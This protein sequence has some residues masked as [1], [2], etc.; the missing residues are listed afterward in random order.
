[1]LRILPFFWR[2]LVVASRSLSRSPA[3]A[4]AAVLSLA[5]GIGFSTAVLS[6]FGTLYFKP[7]PVRDPQKLVLL[8]T[9]DF[10]GKP[11]RWFSYPDYLELKRQGLFSGL[12]AYSTQNL[13]WGDET[14]GHKVTAALS[15]PNY[16]RMLGVTPSFGRFLME[17]PDDENAVVISDTFRKKHFDGRP[18]VGEPLLLNGVPFTIIGV[19]RAG[20]LGVDT[21]VAVDVWI[22][23]QAD[24]RVSPSGEDSMSQRSLQWLTLIGRL[25]D[26]LGL[27]GAEMALNAADRRLAES[28]PPSI[29]KSYR[30]IP[31]ATGDTRHLAGFERF[32]G[33]LTWAVGIAVAI[34]CVN[35][36]SLAMARSLSRRREFALRI[37]LGG[38]RARLLREML[39]ESFTIC[40]AGVV[41]ALA[42]ASALLNILAA[43]GGSDT[44]S[45]H[46]GALDIRSLCFAIAAGVASALF[47]TALPVARSARIDLVSALKLASSHG[48]RGRRFL[49]ARSGLIMTQVALSMVLLV[50]ALVMLRSLRKLSGEELGF[51]PAK[52]FMISLGLG[53]DTNRIADGVE[54]YRMALE[55]VRSL[56]NVEAVSLTSIIF[57]WESSVRGIAIPG[58]DPPRP[59]YM[60][61][62]F[63]IA[64]PGYFGT[65]GMPLL[66][67]R[68]FAGTDDER[69]KRVAVINKAMSRRYWPDANP[70]GKIFS[71]LDHTGYLVPFEV[72]GVV[73]DSKYI[74]LRDDY[75]PQMYFAF[76]QVYDPQMNLVIR[77]SVEPSFLQPVLRR[78]IQS[79][80]PALRWLDGFT[81]TE[82]IDNTLQPLRRQSALLTLL[83]VVAMV[84]TSAGL[85]ASIAQYALQRRHEMGVRLA[86]GERPTGIV[87][88]VLRRGLA[89][90]FAGVGAGL[91]GAFFLGKWLAAYAFKIAP[92]DPTSVLGSALL[93]T[94]VAAAASF[95][96]AYSASRVDPREVLEAS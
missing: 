47:F 22:P 18:A 92:L 4:A 48:E 72:V 64:G 83:A 95:L 53:A 29:E 26:G 69:S 39:T 49:N 24:R 41:L 31:A 1:M 71:T 84:L 20:F 35:L 25:P 59:G 11:V 78:E 60:D 90:T 57:G 2:S 14:A 80:Y 23:L 82:H 9:E 54:N 88:L 75:R 63:T 70:L 37:A 86:L 87:R 77:T 61:L 85:Y 3:F 17:S 44:A 81:L 28:G 36:G 19:A 12:I 89:L 51:Q 42:T 67:G 43:L 8:Q 40:A 13:L 76:P 10:E 73:E 66:A 52:V 56:P 50:G 79:L 46:L 6:I 65:M 68:D 58:F 91:V 33:A 32:L 96:P 94:V 62:D 16:F 15:T 27:K 55:R 30:L 45:L 5:I 21:A 93:L 34:I 7:L 74:G 38:S